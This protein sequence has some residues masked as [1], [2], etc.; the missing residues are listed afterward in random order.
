MHPCDIS[1]YEYGELFIRV[2]AFNKAVEMEQ[3]TMWEAA[4]FTSVNFFRAMGNKVSFKDFALPWDGEFV[5]PVAY[6]A[7]DI[8]QIEELARE[9]GF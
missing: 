5:K 2:R 7:E 4:R 1:G 3:R 9:K 6:T 8:K